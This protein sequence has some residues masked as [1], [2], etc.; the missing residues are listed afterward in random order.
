MAENNGKKFCINREGRPT[1]ILVSTILII[2]N[3]VLFLIFGA[4]WYSFTVLGI[5][6]L[7]IVFL[8]N[9]FRN[10]PRHFASEDTEKVVVSPADGTI[11]AIEEVDETDYFKDRRIVVSIFM[12]IYSVHANW[13]P[14]NGTVLKA[15]HQDGNFHAAFKAKA[16]TENERSLVVIKT[17]E[18]KEIMLRQ[19]AG[20]LARRV[21]TYCKPG[22]ESRI[23]KH[24][25]FI[26]FGSRV[27][28][29]VPLDSLVCVK[30]D[31]KV[32]GDLTILAKLS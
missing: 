12:S 8:L 11:V 2:I 31:Q 28:V 16:S 3:L 13:F 32:K 17:P 22:D 27:D 5:S 21:V 18:G 26:K 29:Y 25:G 4:E 6:V 24:L 23:D 20:A 15:E 9:F 1:L 14:V 19:I 30:L 10:P 7:L